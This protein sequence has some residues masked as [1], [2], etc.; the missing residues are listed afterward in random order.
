M[1]RHARLDARAGRWAASI[2]CEGTAGRKPLGCFFFCG[3]HA[4]E[5]AHLALLR[6]VVGE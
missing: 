4:R 6:K 1:L 2:R 3:E 5:R